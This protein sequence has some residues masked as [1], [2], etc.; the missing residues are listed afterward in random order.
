MPA[1]DDSRLLD[2]LTGRL[3]PLG[4]MLRGGFHAG[5]DDAAPSG[6]GT[7]LL[8]G[9][10]GPELWRRSGEALRDEADAMDAWTR[11]VMDPIGKDIGAT[12]LY[13]FGGPP[14]HPFQRWAKRAEGLHS[15]PLGMLIHPVFGLWHA[16]RAALCF[17]DILPVPESESTSSP[18][19]TCSAKPCLSTCPVSAFSEKKGYDVPACAAHLGTLEGRDCMSLG[20]RARRAC[21]VGR[22]FIYDPKQASFHMQ[23]FLHARQSDSP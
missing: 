23:A 17:P 21:P 1:R 16:Y 9:N 10:A 8:V 5:P 6:A 19:E 14:Y 3:R 4:L 18:C 12:V 11:R 20:C 13:P 15:S 7:V 2:E 22:D